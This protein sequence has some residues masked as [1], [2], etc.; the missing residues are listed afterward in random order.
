[1]VDQQI[2]ALLRGIQIDP[3]L[4][5]VIRQCY[6]DEI[7]EK[8]GHR[9]DVYEAQLRAAMAAIDSEEAR[10]LRLYAS[11][12]V[13]EAVWHNL[14][15]EWQDRRDNLQRN[16]ATIGLEQQANI[17]NLDDALAWIAKLAILYET[18]SCENQH[19]LLRLI[20]ERVVVDHDGNVIEVTLRPP[21]A[22]IQ[23]I[24]ERVKNGKTQS[25]NAKRADHSASP[26]TETQCS[27]QVSFV[28]PNG[29]S[30]L[31]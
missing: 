2:P 26:H 12:K 9:G 15:A 20:V 6:V 30:D 25:E 13:S 18:Q 27:N 8:L 14:W 29:G 4:L 7:A 19:E 10:T 3:D 16:L 5:P 21:F 28:D 24:R 11:G 31:A 22:Y 23:S 17:Q 1:M